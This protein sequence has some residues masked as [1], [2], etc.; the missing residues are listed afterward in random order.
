[1]YCADCDIHELA[2]RIVQALIEDETLDPRDVIYEAL[3]WSSEEQDRCE[4]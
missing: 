1:M 2:D 4:L 3:L